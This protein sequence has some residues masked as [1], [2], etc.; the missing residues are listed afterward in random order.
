M[1]GFFER[2]SGAQAAKVEAKS[3]QNIA[4]F[5]AQVKVQEAKAIRQK[6]A[7]ESKRQAKIAAERQSALEARIASAGGA[8]SPV[9]TE[10]VEEQAIEDEL[11]QLLAG[12]E[13]EALARRAIDQSTLE[14]LAG[15]QAKLQG[16]NLALARNI[17]FGTTLLTGF[18]SVRRQKQEGKT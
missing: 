6:G 10:L 15:Q 2:L 1:G 9:G 11:E 13:T 12:Y 16:R 4:N 18:Q 3:A 5:R 14:T 7:F 17:Q 8:I